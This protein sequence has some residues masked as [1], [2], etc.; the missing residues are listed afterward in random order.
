MIASSLLARQDTVGPKRA[1][2]RNERWP[3]SGPGRVTPSYVPALWPGR[4]DRS[5]RSSSMSCW[6]VRR[7]W[8]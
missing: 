2:P 5:A 7:N 3:G 8:A 1:A 4:S 6:R